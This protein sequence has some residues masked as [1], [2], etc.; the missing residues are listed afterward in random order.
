MKDLDWPQLR[1]GAFRQ[2]SAIWALVFKEFKIKIGKS[3][4]GLFWALV[5]PMVGMTMM[6]SIRWAAGNAEV[7]NVHIVLFV[8]MGF[9][10]YNA[11]RSGINYI[12]HAINAN[13]GLLNYPQVKPIDAIIAR[14]IVTNWLHLLA[15]MLLVFCVW[16]A[17]GVYP[18]F[19]DPWL[20]ITVLVT[21]MALG[22]GVA[23]PL[24]VFGTKNE[25]IFKFIGIISMPLMILSAV[26]F[27]LNEMPQHVRQL[28]AWNPL[29]HLTE[30]FRHGAFGTRLFSE[31]NPLYPEILAIVLNGFGYA[32][33][34]LYRF[35]LMMK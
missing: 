11:F 16:L 15:S 26:V 33:Y 34:Y 9:V 30:G 5:E 12:P 17:I 8:G 21:A 23:L 32:L 10:V 27:S 31:Y 14:F 29:V 18:N 2:R 3:R 20:C 19:P 25:S 28:L 7:N 1:R 22:M 4:I 35:K 6:A 24:T 13:Q